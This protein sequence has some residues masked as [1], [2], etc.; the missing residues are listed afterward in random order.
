MTKNN[1][2][3]LS[4]INK[5]DVSNPLSHL[6]KNT[7]PITNTNV[8]SNISDE[9]WEALKENLKQYDPNYDKWLKEYQIRQ[10]IDDKMALSDLGINGAQVINT[11]L[12]NTKNFH[13]LDDY[14]PLYN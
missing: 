2:D 13:I 14:D 11:A 5:E 9:A 8:D 4:S 3:M 7:P 12:G 6:D 1:N 10:R